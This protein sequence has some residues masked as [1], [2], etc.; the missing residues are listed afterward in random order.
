MSSKMIVI[1]FS[2]LVFLTFSH[3]AL[4][5]ANL[6]TPPAWVKNNIWYKVGVEGENCR[7]IEQLTQLDKQRIENILQR[8]PALRSGEYTPFLLD[9]KRKLFGYSK[10]VNGRSA[11]VVL[12]AGDTDYDVS[13]KG[14]HGWK[15]RDLLNQRGYHR[16]IREKEMTLNVKRHGAV[17]LVDNS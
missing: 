3:L 13:L 11:I 14:M 15:Y 1:G 10:T 5:Q 16:S 8:S 6:S 7:D 17:V 2:T 4:A 12:N 9:E